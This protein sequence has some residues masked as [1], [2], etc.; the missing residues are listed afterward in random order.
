MNIT[1]IT[2]NELTNKVNTKLKEM[3]DKDLKWLYSYFYGFDEWP[4][5]IQKE[6]DK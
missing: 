3:N 2:R 6:E 4:L 1:Y 5:I